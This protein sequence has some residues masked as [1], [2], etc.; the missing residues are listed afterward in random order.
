MNRSIRGKVSKIKYIAKF[1]K[2]LVRCTVSEKDR[3]VHCLANNEVGNK[4]LMLP[5]G[6]HIAV[7]GRLNK[8]N[9]LVVWKMV[10]LDHELVY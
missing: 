4:L 6:T 2:T 9:Q 10:V 1:P 5:E 3:D 8:R 7:Y